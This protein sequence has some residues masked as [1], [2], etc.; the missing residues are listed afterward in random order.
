MAEST[1]ELAGDAISDVYKYSPLT[2]PEDIRL[3]ELLPGDYSAPLVCRLSIVP[4]SDALQYEALSYTWGD[5]SY[6][7]ILYLKPEDSDTTNTSTTLLKI[8]RSLHEALMQLRDP[9]RSRTM[10]VD[11]VCIDQ[12]NLTERGH[13]VGIMR[14]IYHHAIRVLIWLGPEDD[15]TSAFVRVI[16]ELKDHVASRGLSLEALRALKDA[17]LYEEKLAV[18]SEHHRYN[19]KDLLS[20]AFRF[21]RRPWFRRVWVVQEVTAGGSKCQVHIGSHNISWDDLGMATLWFEAWRRVL[22]K[23]ADPFRYSV[24]SSGLRNVLFMWQDRSLTSKTSPSLLN[25]T[26]SFFAT[27]VRDKVYALFS[28]PAFQELR[29]KFD[30]RPDYTM[31]ARQVY[32][33]VTVLTM[34]CSQTLEILHYVDFRVSAEDALAWPSWIPRWDIIHDSSLPLLL[35]PPY[36]VP[37]GT[38]ALMQDHREGIIELGGVSMDYISDVARPLHCAY[39]ARE[40]RIYE[41]DFLAQFWEEILQ[42]SHNEVLREHFNSNEDRFM[43]LAFALTGG[44]DSE[45]K[46]AVK[47]PKSHVGDAIDFLLHSFNTALDWIPSAPLKD[48][49]I[50]LQPKYPGGNRMRFQTILEEMSTK[51]R[52]FYTNNGFLGLGPKNIQPG[53]VIVILYGGYTPFILRPEGD[54]FLLL[55]ECYVNDMMDENALELCRENNDTGEL[56]ERVFRLK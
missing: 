17:D 19:R 21:Y 31:S 52:L 4:L 27:D 10:W 20:S 6:R 8:T 42:R 33:L 55:G 13:Q 49:L 23:V 46:S 54:Y 56:E 40:G 5:L 26:R 34:E 30:F 14:R 9:A 35:Y 16:A 18:Y 43:G 44:L 12:E 29:H 28:F 11:A 7:Q 41:L 36:R 39:R 51:R 47:N 45:R 2:N 3:M 38:L 32:E 1:V 22:C 50:S 53:D 25:A 48:C 24:D 15:K 37:H